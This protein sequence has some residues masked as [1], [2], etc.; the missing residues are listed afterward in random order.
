MQTD[1]EGRTRTLKSMHHGL[2]KLSELDKQLL[3]LLS[4]DGRMPIADLAKKTRA[5]RDTVKYRL[6]RLIKEQ[7]IQG[8]SVV[9][10]YS[11]IG[12]PFS[13]LVRMSLWNLSAEK[14]KA[15]VRYLASEPNIVRSARLAGGWDVEF[16]MVAESAG[17]LDE[18]LMGIRQEFS[19]II[20]D[21][22]VC[23][24]LEER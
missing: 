15:L 18:M 19:E 10:D 2:A 13:L 6:D 12:L 20:K 9:L 4:H 8:F 22:E 17:Q 7:A 24:V 11:R 1:E 14:E 5:N 21:I 3:A 16:K 23:Q